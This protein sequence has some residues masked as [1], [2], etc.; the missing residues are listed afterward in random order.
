MT[1]H[2][3]DGGRSIE[4]F[5]PFKHGRKWV[6]A[7]HLS[8]VTW[9]H[10]LR[11]QEGDYKRSLDLLF[12]LSVEP[13]AVLRKLRYPDVDRV[14]QQ[15]FDMLPSE[16]REAIAAG[17]IPMKLVPDPVEEIPFQEETTDPATQTTVEQAYEQAAHQEE[18]NPNRMP[19][20]E[21][22]DR[23]MQAHP[24]TPEIEKGD[25]IGFEVH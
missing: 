9:D 1:V 18:Y 12:D 6:R 5:L 7:I 23:D 21:E 3:K 4:L 20:Q 2:H 16:I 22:I 10:T 11:W 14:M 8:P 24:V 15:F 13:E 19:T 17:Q 25:G